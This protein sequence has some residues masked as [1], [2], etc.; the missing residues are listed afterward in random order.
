[1]VPCLTAGERAKGSG[2]IVA[3]VEGTLAA[4]GIV[5]VVSPAAGAKGAREAR[6]A[7]E[8]IEVGDAVQAREV[9]WVVGVGWVKETEG[10]EEIR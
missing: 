5:V 6:G 4:M 7:G 8:A 10:A 3:M 9:V 2:V 1:M